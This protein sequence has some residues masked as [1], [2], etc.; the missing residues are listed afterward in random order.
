MHLITSK[1]IPSS[2]NAYWDSLPEAW[3]ALSARP[4]L[5]LTTPYQADSPEETTL[6]KMLAGC[7]LNPDQYHILTVQADQQIAWHSLQHTLSPQYVLLL[8]IQPVQLGI[9]A[10]FQLNEINQFN[11]CII[12]P[13]LSLEQLDQYTDAKKALWLNALKPTFIG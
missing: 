7:Q 3:Q 5:V 12:I 6:I 13:S 1:I 11:N 10:L 9:A 8:G 2:E 4:L